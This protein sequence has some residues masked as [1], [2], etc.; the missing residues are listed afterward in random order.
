CQTNIGNKSW[1]F[2]ASALGGGDK[3]NKRN[4]V[5]IYNVL[6]NQKRKKETENALVSGNLQKAFRLFFMFSQI[7]INHSS[8]K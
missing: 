6:P 2:N 5:R 8:S 3:G 1:E 7:K 4:G